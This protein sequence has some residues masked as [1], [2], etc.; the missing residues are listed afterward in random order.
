MIPNKTKS[1]FNPWP[2]TIIVF[3]S[4]AICA[5]VS[6]VIFCMRQKVDLVAA[7]YYD[8]EVRYQD[9]LDR[10]NHASSLQAPAKVEY[11]TATRRITVSLPAEHLNQSLKGWIQ[12]YRPAASGL[13]QKLALDVDATGAQIID[14][15]SLNDGLWHVR[16]SWKQNGTDYYFDQKLVIGEK[17]GS[18]PGVSPVRTGTQ[19]RGSRASTDP[20]E[21]SFENPGGARPALWSAATC[22]RFVCL[23][24]LSA[25]QRRAERRGEAP[26][27]ATLCRTDSFTI[28]DGD[29]SPAESGDE[30]PHSKG[31][32]GNVIPT[33]SPT[34]E[35]MS[36][37][38]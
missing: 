34:L 24:D 28:R 15:K 18:S 38:S 25:K 9:Q 12:L 26:V 27:T 20:F 13:D 22:R 32:A 30:P 36:F 31:C 35:N 23:A 4:V 1:T 29:K 8:Q 17:P 11:N 2:V 3:F 37:G 5:A 7:D 10:I 19:S 16:V 33:F 14:A 6:V 21:A